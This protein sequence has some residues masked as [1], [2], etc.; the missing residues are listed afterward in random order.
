MK[1]R[2][3][4]IEHDLIVIG[5]NLS[6]AISG[7]IIT[8]VGSTISG[9]AITEIDFGDALILPGWIDAHV[10]FNEP[11]RADWEG[12]ST[13]SRALAAGGGTMFFDM[14]LNSVYVARSR[15]LSTLRR[16]AARHGF[17]VTVAGVWKP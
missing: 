11:G 5:K 3:I 8:A 16:E 2:A 15:V 10:H 13:G 14:P 9:N 7:E 17:G 4:A 6:L 1:D 12:F